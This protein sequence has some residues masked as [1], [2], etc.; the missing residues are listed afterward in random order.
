MT[1]NRH[2]FPFT[3]TGGTAKGD[4]GWLYGAIQQLRWYP[5]TVDT[6]QPSTLS[7]AV[8]PGSVRDTGTGWNIF[9][10]SNQMGVGFTKAPRQ[11]S[12]DASG[13]PYDTGGD[14]H[15]PIVFTQDK[16]RMKLTPAD[17]GIAFS[18]KLYVWT[19]D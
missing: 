11:T 9:S 14:F 12:H 17:T 3:I 2:V 8:V 19:V 15:E 18:G 7:L 5:D 6:G 16:L 10:Q 1:I 4:T 13:D